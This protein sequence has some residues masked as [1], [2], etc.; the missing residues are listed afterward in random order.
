MT[1]LLDDQKDQIIEV[2]SG[3]TR[4]LTITTIAQKTGIDRHAV[5]RHLDMLEVLGKVRKIEKGTAKK[6]VLVTSLPISGLI[7]ISSDLILI[8]NTHLTIQYT[9]ASALKYLSTTLHAVVGKRLDHLNLPLLSSPDIITALT[10]F[11]FEKPSK[12]I[13][14]DSAGIWFEITIIGFSL[15][16]AP[17]QIALICTDISDKKRSEE[18]LRIAQEKYS[19]AFKSSPDAVMISDLETGEIIEANESAC[20]MLEYTPVDLIGNT[21]IGLSIIESETDRELIIHN[22]S[23]HTT[24]NRTELIMRRRSGEKFDAS[25]SAN[26]IK[27]GGKKYLLTI[28]RDISER[29]KS[30]EKIRKSEELYRLLADNTNDVIWIMDIASGQF[31][32]VSPSVERLRGFT[33]EEVVS[34]NIREV[35]TDESYARIVQGLP[36]YLKLVK[37]GTATP[38]HVS[39]V[40]Q[41][42]RNGSII[43]TEVVT[44]FLKEPDGRIIRVLGVSRNITER[45]QTEEKLRRSE[46]HYRLLAES[47]KDVV[48]ILDPETLFFKYISPSITSL[49]GITPEELQKV[50]VEEIVSPALSGRIKNAC[51]ERSTQYVITNDQF[52]YYTDEIE[53]LI[54]GRSTWTEVIS[55]FSTNEETGDLEIIGVARDITDKKR[56]HRD[57]AESESKYRLI[58]EHVKDV[59]WILDPSTERFI[60]VSPSVLK[61]RG[62]YAHEVI[63]KNLSEVIS[64]KSYLKFSYRLRERIQKFEAGDDSVLHEITEIEQIHREGHEIVTEMITTLVSGSDRKIIHIIGVSR[65]ITKQ[66]RDEEA[67]QKSEAMF[68]SI[69]NE[70]PI[71]HILCDHYGTIMKLNNASLR[72]WGIHDA[73]ILEGQI[74]WNHILLTNEEKIDIISGKIVKGEFTISFDHLWE[75]GLIPTNRSGTVTLDITITPLFTMNKTSVG[76]LIHLLDITEKIRIE[77]ELQD[78]YQS[79]QEVHRMM[80]P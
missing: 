23:T 26:I 57:L 45:L 11:K 22:T 64:S 52:H 78:T 14:Q 53:L 10:R 17:N 55:R 28:T 58:S 65:E 50:P 20:K 5:A 4:S 9:N 8:F 61:V 39:R 32:Y 70:S 60:Y 33:P 19:I 15:L 51:Q 21:K 24:D 49:I 41:P 79:L 44:T 13:L 40:D 27:M 77:S 80:H 16:Q 38:Y 68:R 7:D 31:T 75:T 25:T 72:I 74:I 63:G 69:F 12:V 43:P 71:G 56:A 1:S 48:W 2:L 46:H 62:F 54:Q 3:E 66:K 37:E 30:E 29:K 67:L 34:Q 59:V 6:Y 36:H 73:T 35:M 47:I 42:H 76:Y 18:E